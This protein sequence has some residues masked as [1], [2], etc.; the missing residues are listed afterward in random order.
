MTSAIITDP[1]AAGISPERLQQVVSELAALGRKLPGSEKAD[2]ACRYIGAQ[3]ASFGVAHEFQEF[4]AFISWPEKASLTIGGEVLPA[5]GSAFTA[6]TPTQGLTGRVA[7]S[8]EPGELKGAFLLIDGLPRYDAC[9]SAQRAGALGVIAISHGPQRHYVQAS[10]LWGAPTGPADM[11][12][13]PTIPAVQVSRNTAERLERAIAEGSPVTMASEIRTEWRQVKQPVA[14]IEG[15]E[16][17]YILLGAHYC[18][19]G[20]GATD[21][22]AGVALLIELARLLKQQPKPRYGVK[23]AFWTGHEQ[24][25]YAGSSWYADRFRD[26]LYSD[27]IAYLNVD[28][29]GSRGGTTKALRNTTAEL[30]SYVRQVLDATIGKQTREEE[31]FVDRSVKRLDPYID[32]RRSA[33]NSDQSFS[34]IGLATAQVSAFLPA[35]SPEHL[36]GSGLA[37]WWHTDQD[38]IEHMDAAV[39]AVDTLI[40]R[41]LVAGLIDASALPFR[42]ETMAED[43][44]AGLRAYREAAPGLDDIAHLT[45]LAERLAQALRGWTPTGA[46]DPLLLRLG[47]HLN[48]VLYHARSAFEFDLG[49]ASRILPGLAPALTLHRLDP[50]AARMARVQLRQRANRIAH[51]LARAIELVESTTAKAR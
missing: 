17:G 28:I 21:N 47:R 12:L 18:T 38:T 31:D 51:G 6:S 13:L 41:N 1:A 42:S 30:A 25:G 16:P 40:Y 19:W 48:P 7:R 33:R 26:S 44:L 27:A 34:G 20:D 9:M 29:V 3:L 46:D 39:L 37:W 35:A 11:A 4:D 45:S 5:N 15:R 22:T 50:D 49:R 36:H 2:E 32:P 24:G 43:V 23:F 10:P 14:E 8:L